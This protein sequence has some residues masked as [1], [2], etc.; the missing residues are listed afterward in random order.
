MKLSTVF[1]PEVAKAI[2][3]YVKRELEG[4][5]VSIIVDEMHINGNLYLH[6]AL[7][8]QKSEDTPVL[9]FWDCKR[10][11]GNKATDVASCISQEMNSLE[12]CGIH[13]ISYV[14]DHC[15]AMRE[16]ERIF[17][18]VTQEYICRIPCASHVLNNLLEDFVK[19]VE[20]INTVWTQ[21]CLSA[22]M[23]MI[24]FTRQTHRYSQ[25]QPF[26]SCFTKHRSIILTR[27]SSLN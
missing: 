6:F 18:Q 7:A 3:D 9:F 8:T 25:M 16:T 20:V 23:I 5:F 4:C 1:I 19:H 26:W 27:N 11:S 13:C 10:T 22:R 21:V 12:E 17:N 2:K 15:N 14:S 24:R